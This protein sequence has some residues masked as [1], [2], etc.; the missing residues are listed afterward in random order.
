MATS[1]SDDYFRREFLNRKKHGSSAH[2]IAEIAANQSGSLLFADCSRQ[3][4]LD[5]NLYN[6]AERKNAIFKAELLA[7]ITADFRDQVREAAKRAAL[8]DRRTGQ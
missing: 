1:Q 5:F 8:A 7:K 2:V 3:I 4:R 6:A